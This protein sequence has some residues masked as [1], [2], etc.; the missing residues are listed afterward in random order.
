[1]Q[2]YGQDMKREISVQRRLA[3]AT[4]ELMQEMEGE[5]QKQDLLIDHLNKQI[6]DVQTQDE[7]YNGQLIAQQEETITAKEILHAALCEMDRIKEE[8]REYLGRWKA[9]MVEIGKRDEAIQ[10]A[11][12]VVE[13][14]KQTI[15]NT[16]TEIEGIQKDINAKQWEQEKIQESIDNTTNEQMLLQNRVEEAIKKEKEYQTKIVAVRINLEKAETLQ[17]EQKQWQE[18]I[19][20]TEKKYVKV[21]ADIQE[22]NEKIQNCVSESL[23][24]KHDASHMSE[25]IKKL[26]QQLNEKELICEVQKNDIAKLKMEHISMENTIQNLAH[27]FQ[28]VNK[29]YSEKEKIVEDYENELKKLADLASKKTSLLDRLNRRYE[30]L[31][32]KIISYDGGAGVGIGAGDAEG[33]APS[34]AIMS[35]LQH[36]IG[37]L[38]KEMR[39][40]EQRCDDLQKQWI[41]KQTLL[42]NLL[43]ESE[44]EQSEVETLHAQANVLYHKKMRLENEVQGHHSEFLELK[45]SIKEINK[46]LKKFQEFIHLFSEQEKFLTNEFQ[47]TELQFKENL[48]DKEKEMS[49]QQVKIE[50]VNELVNERNEIMQKIEI[51]ERK[52]LL[53]E[54]KLQLEIE[55]QQALNPSGEKKELNDMKM[56][57]HRMELRHQQL[58][59]KQEQMV[60]E[61]EVAIHKKELLQLKNLGKAR[62]SAN[63]G[64]QNPMPVETQL[65]KQIHFL[66]TAI[67]SNIKEQ[68]K[69]KKLVFDHFDDR[70]KLSKT[71]QNLQSEYSAVTEQC[72]SLQ[73]NIAQ[74]KF[75][76]RL[77]R[78]YYVFISYDLEKLIANNQ[79]KK[80]PVQGNNE[81]IDR[82]TSL[83]SKNME[84]IFAEHSAELNKLNSVLKQLAETNPQKQTWFQKT[85][86]S[87]GENQKQ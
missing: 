34:Q 85:L 60:Q 17:G 80:K 12:K 47:I 77:V 4:E 13:S 87:L 6:Y 86:D 79:T 55:T 43:N 3:Y 40:S 29:Q 8:K 53:Y 50:Q 82:P 10:Q 31:T 19:K 52:T 22:V 35:P 73:E 38:N 11:K 72:Q 58:K 36:T 62:K 54:R 78:L 68:K 28:E 1:I 16:E 33:D 14:L 45:N 2:Q 75:E 5:K 30:Q 74:K 9:C 56:E 48:K 49:I 37:H 20:I 81:N 15:S 7:I 32:S 83:R 57:V 71:L 76:K 18:Q 63:S 67:E 64:N 61:L 23:T 46:D 70:N 25:K 69:Y 59:K 27:M 84:K 44:K 24:V 39:E 26:Q 65:T 41:T 51:I 21:I 42:V 66:K